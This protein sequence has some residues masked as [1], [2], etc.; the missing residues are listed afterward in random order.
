[1]G[2]QGHPPDVDDHLD[3]FRSKVSILSLQAVS[4]MRFN[5]TPELEKTV[6]FCDWVLQL[7]TQHSHSPSQ[8]FQLPAT[9]TKS[10]VF[11]FALPKLN[12]TDR[13]AA[14]YIAQNPGVLG[15]NIALHIARSLSHFNSRIAPKLKLHGFRNERGSGGWFPPPRAISRYIEG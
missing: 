10:L 11:D 12:A 15:K 7:I 3:R 2:E 9:G 6:E 8:P 4:A 13:G 1:M 14:I 5:R